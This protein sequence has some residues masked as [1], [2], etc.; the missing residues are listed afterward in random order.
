MPQL[1]TKFDLNQEV[2]CLEYD[3]VLQGKVHEITLFQESD[4][5][6]ESYRVLVHNGEGTCTFEG[7]RHASILFE[8]KDKLLASL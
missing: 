5:L 4:H 2:W 6:G 7:S 3:R 1:T 8:T